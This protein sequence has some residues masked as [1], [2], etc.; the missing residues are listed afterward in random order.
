MQAT[1]RVRFEWG[2]RTFLMGI[3]NVS[4]DSFAGDGESSAEG[5]LEK[6]IRMVSEGA[7][8]IDVGG[9]S[10]RPGSSPIPVHEEAERVL[11]AVRA[12]RSKLNVP[13][14]VDTYKYDI[15]AAALEAGAD[16]I[17]D[18]WGLKQ[19]PRLADLAA[20]YGAGLLLMANQR[21]VSP[22]HDVEFPDVVHVVIED[23][24]RATREALLRGVPSEHIMIDPGIGFGKT[25]PQNLTLL[26]RLRELRR[27]GYPVL[28]GTSR[29][30]V[31]GHVLQLP[32]SKRL[33]ATAATVALAIER[34]A[35]I[36][37]VH[38]VKQM[39]RVCR[40]ADAVVRG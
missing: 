35:D 6:A 7:D 4:P 37:R 16:I 13:I 28:V 23:L 31:L 33:E 8:I 24:A 12:I 11:P 15:A 9:E 29:K 1:R 2:T 20:T 27:L 30:S 10:T 14:S 21:D 25:Q 32:A 22:N 5:A 40:V 39:W 26:R 17:N 36:V 38:D 18:I 3:V 19:E 34:G